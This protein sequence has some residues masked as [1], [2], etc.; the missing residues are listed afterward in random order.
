M[1]KITNRLANIC[2]KLSEESLKSEME[3]KHAACIIQG[4]KVVEIGF[5]YRNRS[6]IGNMNL[7]SVHAE[8]DVLCKFLKRTTKQ[9]L[10]FRFGSSKSKGRD[11]PCCQRGDKAQ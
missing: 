1:T 6:R 8:T 2:H 11:S 10:R 3:S 5:N 4:G 7:P 9:K